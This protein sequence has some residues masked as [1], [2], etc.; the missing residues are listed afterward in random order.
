MNCPVIAMG[1][2]LFN[3][4]VSS[5]SYVDSL[6]DV[7]SGIN[8]DLSRELSA[9]KNKQVPPSIFMPRVVM[10]NKCLFL[11]SCRR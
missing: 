11:L 3:F 4:A 1:C 5:N 8:M 6:N 7:C 2:F 9:K 10:K